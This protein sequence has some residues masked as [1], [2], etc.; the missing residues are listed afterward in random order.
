MAVLL[1]VPAVAAAV[2]AAPATHAVDVLDHEYRPAAIEIV[3]GDTVRWTWR[4]EDRHSVTSPAVFD[5]HPQCSVL[6]PDACG[7]AGTT[8]SW[9][10]S[11]P[12]T[13][14]YGCRVH[15]DRMQGTITVVAAPD[16]SPSP[17]P[18]PSEPPPSETSEPAPEPPPPSPSPSPAAS[19]APSPAPSPASSPAPPRRRSAPSLGFGEASEVDASPTPGEPDRDTVAPPVVSDASPEPLEPFPAAPSPSPD[20]LADDVVAIGTPGDGG[21]GALRL[22]GATAL[23]VTVLAFGRVVLFG[24]PWD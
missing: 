18:E 22:A 7:A 8:F 5:S 16:S 17:E 10:S 9:T 14:E 12:A 2:A 23:A 4:G 19:P 1:T 11:E 21:R 20:A 15:P 24:R 13:I 6:T 3:A